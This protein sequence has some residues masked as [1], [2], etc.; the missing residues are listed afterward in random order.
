MKQEEIA[1]V[2]AVVGGKSP[3]PDTDGSER[4]KLIVA[5]ATSRLQNG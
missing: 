1:T 3:A 4:Q 2:S 5:K